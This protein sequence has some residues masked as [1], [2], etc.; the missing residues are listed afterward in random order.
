MLQVRLVCAYDVG[1][2]RATICCS[3]NV[4]PLGLLHYFV[5]VLQGVRATLRDDFTGTA[6]S[7]RFGQMTRAG[8][9]ADLSS[10]MLSRFLP[11]QIHPPT[12]DPPF[13]TCFDAAVGPVRRDIH[14]PLRFTGVA[15]TT[16]ISLVENCNGRV[17][18]TFTKAGTSRADSSSCI[19]ETDRGTGE[20]KFF[21][22]L[23]PRTDWQREGLWKYATPISF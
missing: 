14:F 5:E 7:L 19:H 4:T 20:I 22:A 18:S 12:N 1:Y 3:R 6:F 10:H 13:A 9:R 16:L 23:G 21:A 17:C 8:D 15:G 2:G 11:F